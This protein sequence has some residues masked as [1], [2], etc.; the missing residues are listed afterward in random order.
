MF[1][2]I[3]KL[4]QIYKFNK[5]YNWVAKCEKRN[6]INSWPKEIAR[7]VANILATSSLIIL[8]FYHWQLIMKTET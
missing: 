4:S 6:K 7:L 8:C 3:L 5:K 2:A 1:V